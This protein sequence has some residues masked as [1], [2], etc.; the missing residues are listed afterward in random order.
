MLENTILNAL[1]QYHIHIQTG[2]YNHKSN[3]SFINNIKECEIYL[4]QGNMVTYLWMENNYKVI[5]KAVKY[6]HNI[7]HR[8]YS[9][10]DIKY[11]GDEHKELNKCIKFYKEFFEKSGIDCNYMDVD[12]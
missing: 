11:S 9:K 5:S 6:A 4:E 2:L 7:L 8:D 3:D 1:R 10:S 12:F